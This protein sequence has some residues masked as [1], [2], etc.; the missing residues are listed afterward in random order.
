VN[1]QLT[2][3]LWK[4]YKGKHENKIGGL[5][6]DETN[7]GSPYVG[8]VRP[9]N[10]T[11]GGLGRLQAGDK[12]A[13]TDPVGNYNL[14]SVDGK[15]VPCTVTHEGNTMTVK[16][17]RFDIN[18]DGSCVSRI[19]FSIGGGGENSREVKAAYTRDG[20]TLTMKWEGA[21]MTTGTIE[22]GGFTMNNE[23]MIFAYRK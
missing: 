22:R 12:I 1:K 4:E 14:V 21:G 15:T 8:M 23:G 6:G 7:L 20:A 2:R 16:S 3:L 10:R 13:E 19:A 9:C 18:A 11:S 17:G 5:E